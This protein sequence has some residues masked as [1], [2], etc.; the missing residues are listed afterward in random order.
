[1]RK[2]VINCKVN[3]KNDIYIASEI[4]KYYLVNDI[5]VG[6]K[7]FIDDVNEEPLVLKVIKKKVEYK[8]NLI[9]ANINCV[10]EENEFEF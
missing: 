3:G 6:N 4:N 8:G 5:E 2:A 7:L 9:I 10:I 1:M